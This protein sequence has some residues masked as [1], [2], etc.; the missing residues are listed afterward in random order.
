MQEL[1]DQHRPLIQ[2]EGEDPPKAKAK[3]KAKSKAKAKPK[4]KVTVQ[5]LYDLL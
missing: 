5:D 1:E 2:L 4:P 3:P